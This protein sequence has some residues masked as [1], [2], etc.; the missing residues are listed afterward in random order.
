MSRKQLL[1]L[2]S[3]NF[4]IWTVGNG[5]PPLLPVYA[6][7]LGAAPALA[8]YY[9]S[10]NC[11]ALAVGTVLGGWLSDR[12]G[13]RRRLLIAAGV[14]IIP[15]AWLMSRVTNMWQLA[16]VSTVLAFLIG[17]GIV[18]INILAGLFAGET[19]RGKVF[20]ILALNSPLGSLMGGLTAGPIAERWGY[21]TLFIAIALLYAFWPLTALL[22]QDK[23]VVRVRPG[24]AATADE[25]PGLGRAFFLLILASLAAG[26]AV[27]VRSLGTSLVM[28]DLGFG[29]AAISSTTAVSGVVTLPLPLLIGWLSD[30]LGRKRFLTLGYLAGA[31]GLLTLAG[32]A[33]LWHFWVATSFGILMFNVN[34]GVGSALVTD[35]VPQASLGRGLSLFTTTTWMGGIVGF[36]VTGQAIQSF[37]ASA[38]FI[39]CAFLPLVAILLLIPIREVRREEVAV[40][41]A[42]A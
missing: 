42:P 31:A 32:A 39:V 20:G 12:L 30:R 18:L 40:K 19:E 36:A 2:F 11:L 23:E 5:I 24:A 4:I 16:A 35:L 38:T 28:D 22:V 15:T 34:S 17:T 26:V 27:Y 13:R 8:G 21:P 29:A 33:S 1:A 7:Q 9:L 10:L 25:R 6:R 14:L 41:V 37:G 3:C